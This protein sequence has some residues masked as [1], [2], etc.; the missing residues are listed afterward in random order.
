[1]SSYTTI[2]SNIIVTLVCY[3]SVV[4]LFN[5]ILCSIDVLCVSVIN[6]LSIVHLQLLTE[7]F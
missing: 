6:E 1:M 7:N 4:L 2:R 3:M 5:T